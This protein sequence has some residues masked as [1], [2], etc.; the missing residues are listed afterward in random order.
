VATVSTKAR[1]SFETT[2]PET[3]F[4]ESAYAG[5]LGRARRVPQGDHNLTCGDDPPRTGRPTWLARPSVSTLTHYQVG[6]PSPL[7]GRCSDATSRSRSAAGCASSGSAVSRS[8]A[9]MY[10]CS[11]ASASTRS[12]SSCSAKGRTPAPRSV[13]DAER[14]VDRPG[15][16]DVHAARPHGRVG[17]LSSRRAI[18]PPILLTERRCGRDAHQYPWDGIYR[19]RVGVV[20][21]CAPVHR[22][23]DHLLC[24]LS[25]APESPKPASRPPLGS[26]QRT[27]SRR[28]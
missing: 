23:R 21:G 22:P 26:R 25:P 10:S 15:P 9:A 7:S 5:D 17:E 27:S 8:I 11:H 1:S 19:P 14:S 2:T 28:R 6:R 4:P 3:E 24:D 20:L 12:L 16:L 18:V 13:P